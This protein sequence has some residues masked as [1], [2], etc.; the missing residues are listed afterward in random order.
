MNIETDL[1]PQGPFTHFAKISNGHNSATRL[2]IPF[3]RSFASLCIFTA[4]CIS[5][6]SLLLQ[7]RLLLW[8]I[9]LICVWLVIVAVRRIHYTFLRINSID[10]APVEDSWSRLLSSVCRQSHLS[11]LRF[12]LSMSVSRSVC[13]SVGRRLVERQSD[14][15]SEIVLSIQYALL[16]NYIQHSC[17]PGSSASRISEWEG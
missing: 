2:P 3:C 12:T 1:W 7:K 9:S 16:L 11:L 5:P 17:A 6:L 13:R 10:L 14:I 4:N 8:V 15:D